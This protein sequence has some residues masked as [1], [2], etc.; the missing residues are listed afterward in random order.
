MKKHILTICLLFAT[1]FVASAKCLVLKLTNGTCAYYQ[2]SAEQHPVM[3]ITDEGISIGVSAYTFSQI[4]GFYIS[5]G[6]APVGVEAVRL[7]DESADQQIGLD[8]REVSLSELPAG[9]HLV[10]VG[11]SVLKVIKK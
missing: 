9:I 7:S 4:A 10:R 6:D 11:D 8:G 3:R 2:I 5:E 1:C